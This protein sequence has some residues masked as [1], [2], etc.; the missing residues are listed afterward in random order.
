MKN[1]DTITRHV[2]VAIAI[3]AIGYGVLFFG[4]QWQ[5]EHKGPWV[6]SFGKTEA[7]QPMMTV[8]QP[9]LRIEGVEI[10]F[11]DATNAVEAAPAPFRFD[12]HLNVPY[13]V[14]FGECI[15]QD[16]RYLPGTVTLNLLR[17]HEVEFLPRTLTIDK[18]EHAW[19]PARRIEVSATNKLPYLI[20]K[21]E[22]EPV[23]IP[24]Y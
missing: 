2:G 20:R 1:S 3:A 22:S 13:P 21:P 24:G 4:I 5:R 19:F 11:F 15:F 7:G 17:G 12:Q 8:S 14:P 16:L 23:K 18:R 10:V 9:Y 6:V